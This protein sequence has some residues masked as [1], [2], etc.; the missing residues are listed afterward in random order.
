MNR[1]WVEL[2]KKKLMVGVLIVQALKTL[3]IQLEELREGKL[4][5]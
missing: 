3:D 5:K 4:N 2:Q 1:T